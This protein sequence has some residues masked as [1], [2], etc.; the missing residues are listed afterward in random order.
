VSDSYLWE[1]AFSG[2]SVFA[3]VA[4]ACGTLISAYAAYRQLKTKGAPGEISPSQLHEIEEARYGSRSFEIPALANYYNQALRRASLAFV[5]SLLFASI[6]FGVIVFAFVTHNSSDLAGTVVKVTSGA[7]IEAVS[8]LFFVQATN[9][10]KNMG[11]FFEKLRLDRLNAEARE[12]IGEIEAV[13]MRDQL[14]AQL[15]LKYSGI[16]RLLVGDKELQ[17][18]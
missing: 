14:R 2:F 4:V 8:S 18:G 3:S 15:I 10:Q 6:G 1:Y 13:G 16:D 7:I 11:D 12:M 9:A 5:F 17:N